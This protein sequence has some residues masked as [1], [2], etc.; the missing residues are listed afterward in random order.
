MRILFV[1]ILAIIT[2]I[3]SIETMTKQS[4]MTGLAALAATTLA[5]AAAS[6]FVGSYLARREK[7]YSALDLVVI[8]TIASLF[9]FGGFALAYWSRF[10]INAVYVVVDGFDWLL[11]A[12]FVALFVTRKSDALSDVSYPD[13]PGRDKNEQSSTLQQLRTEAERGNAQAQYALGGAYYNGNGV[14]RNA[15]QGAQWLLKAAEG[16]YAPA[17]C[18]L[19]VM[20]QNGVGVNQ[21]L[22]DALK[23]YHRAAEQG[24]AFACHN[25]GSLTATGFKNKSLSFFQRMHF[26]RATSNNVEAY[27][28]FTLAAKRGYARS[29]KDKS[30]LERIMSPVEISMA[31]RLAEEFE[32]GRLGR[33]APH[34]RRGPADRGEYRQTAGVL[35]EGMTAHHAPTPDG[36]AH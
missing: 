35:A 4:V 28:W 10:Q 9:A 2:L 13:R 34:Q 5:F 27:K 11:I 24:D 21:S 31:Q 25:L 33:Q 6:T 1:F 14:A 19:G 7:R 30:I 29:L 12:M 3:S 23:W 20:Y 15:A 26:A 36:Q 32:R 16:G 8:G 18:D 22:K 17:Q